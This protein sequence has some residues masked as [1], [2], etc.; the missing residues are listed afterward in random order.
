MFFLDQNKGMNPIFTII[1]AT[2]NSEKTLERTIKSLLNQSFSN[3]EY[4]VI[5]GNSTDNTLAILNQFK[6]Q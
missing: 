3:F 5:D 1:T 6:N 4:L 2:F